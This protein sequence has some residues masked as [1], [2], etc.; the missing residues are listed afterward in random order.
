MDIDQIVRDETARAVE[1]LVPH[2]AGPVTD[3]RL[4]TVL[5][6]FALRIEQAARAAALSDL[7]TAEDVAAALDIIPRG[8]RAMIARRHARDASFGLRAGRTW[9]VTGAELEQLRQAQR[10]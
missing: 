6:A 2:G 9:L 1:M 4:R 3:T 5:A 7:H 10:R 8:A